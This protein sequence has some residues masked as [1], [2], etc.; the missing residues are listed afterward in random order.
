MVGRC[1]A[2]AAH[3]DCIASATATRRR[4]RGA[5]DRE[6]DADR[7]RQVRGDGRGLRDDRQIV[8]AEHLVTAAGDRFA[9]CR[10]HAGEDVADTGKTGAAEVE[11]AAAVVQQRRVG[12]PQ[13]HRHGGV[14]LVARRA[15]RVVALALRPQPACCQVAV[16]AGDLQVV[17]V[18]HVEQRIR[19]H[20][21]GTRLDA[22]QEADELLLQ[23]R[24]RPLA[25]RLSAPGVG[26]VRPRATHRRYRGRRCGSMGE[27]PRGVGHSTHFDGVGIETAGGEMVRMRPSRGQRSPIAV[28]ETGVDPVTPRFSGVCSAD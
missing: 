14:A 15:D 1:V 22:G 7:T 18:C 16:P 12:R 19:W 21:R 24:T 10:D 26:V 23:R 8:T 9:R 17:E 2:E 28:V 3:G 27:A 13:C 5:V 25:H 6:R 11:A 20:R 4:A